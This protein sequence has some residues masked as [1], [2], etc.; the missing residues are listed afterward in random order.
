MEECKHERVEEMRGII[1]CGSCGEEIEIII[2]FP[3]REKPKSKLQKSTESYNFFKDITKE[4]FKL[5][6]KYYEITR[7]PLRRTIRKMIA[8]G[9]FYV[10]WKKLKGEVN[11]DEILEKMKLNKKLG[12]RGLKNVIDMLKIKDGSW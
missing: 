5:Y 6:K 8:Y 7:N 4:A 2:G 11:E 12:Q 3:K 10:T 1:F 9:C